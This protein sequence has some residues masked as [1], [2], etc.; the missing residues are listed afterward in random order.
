[1][2]TTRNVTNMW[3]ENYHYLFSELRDPRYISEIHSKTTL[4]TNLASLGLMKGGGIG[5][6][7]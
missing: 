3:Q 4:E 7:M 5:K 2:A 1:M 6:N